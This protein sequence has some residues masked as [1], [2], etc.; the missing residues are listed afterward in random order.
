MLADSSTFGS[1]P[2]SPYDY[3]WNVKLDYYT[4]NDATVKEIPFPR[5]AASE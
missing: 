1:L 5:T 3:K 4:A 2:D